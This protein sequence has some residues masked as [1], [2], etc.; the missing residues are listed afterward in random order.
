MRL[1]S[2]G[3][4]ATVAALLTLTACSDI[5]G[6]GD[7]NFISGDGSLQQ[8]AIDQRERPIDM[9][10]ET[11]DGE[12]LD[13]ADLRGQVVVVNV[14]GSWCAPCRGEMPDLVEVA[15]ETEGMAQFVGVNIRETSADNAR[16]FERRFEVPYPSIYSPDSKALLGFS[17]TLTPNSIPATVVLDKQ[18]RQAAYI[19][20]AVTS[21][22]TLKNI[23]EEAAAEDG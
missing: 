6:T 5:A 13:L 11:L 3:A 12:Q 7:K 15:E 21:A 8:I 1:R 4:A 9:S 23:I 18:G 22:T 17:G 10:G 14:W 19:L 16:A 20:G 2:L